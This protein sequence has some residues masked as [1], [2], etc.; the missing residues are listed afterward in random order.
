MH[1]LLWSSRVTGGRSSAQSSDDESSLGARFLQRVTGMV[2][3]QW[4]LDPTTTSRVRVLVLVARFG[5]MALVAENCAFIVCISIMI[6]V[7]IDG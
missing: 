2:I 5:D 4:F 3:R 1:K 7:W 6:T